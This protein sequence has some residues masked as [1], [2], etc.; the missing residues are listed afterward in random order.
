MPTTSKHIANNRRQCGDSSRRL[1]H[2]FKFAHAEHSAPA[3]ANL[4]QPTDFDCLPTT[5]NA[6]KHFSLSAYE[7]SLRRQLFVGLAR[8]LRRRRVRGE[9]Y[10]PARQ[11]TTLQQET[12]PVGRRTTGT[13]SADRSFPRPSNS[14]NRTQAPAAAARLKGSPVCVVTN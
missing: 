7:N 6:A 5:C 12:R 13:E 8:S 2:K 3:Q 9:R 14:T 4:E 11:F 1:Q 10:L